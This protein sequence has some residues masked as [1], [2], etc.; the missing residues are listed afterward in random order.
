MGAGRPAGDSTAARPAT[1]STA[2]A[3]SLSRVS[4]FWVTAPGLTPTQFTALRKT[5]A[6]IATGTVKRAGRP[7]SASA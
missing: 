1:I 6:P 7:A 2:S 3:A 5:M 4:T